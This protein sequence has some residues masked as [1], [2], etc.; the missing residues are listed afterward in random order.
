MG[1]KKLLKGIDLNCINLVN[2][3]Y[4]NVIL[5]NK[6]EVDEHIISTTDTQHRI[7]F[8]L[9]EGKSGHLFR[10][11]EI[12][13]LLSA[14]FSK[15]EDNGIPVY[16]HR[17]QI[18]VSGATENVKTLLKQL[19]GSDYFAAIQLKNGIVEIYG[20][21]NLLKTSNYDYESQSPL[22]GAVIQMVSKIE[23]YEPPYV[24]YAAGFEDA[25]FNDLFGGI[26]GVLSGDFNDDFNDDFYIGN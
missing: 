16:E 7:S 6:S 4:Q 23:E 10:A 20:F 25:H 9:L 13:S 24:Y 3:Y 22:G 11:S 12:T 21:D 17:V 5:I 1:C 18:P 14:S 26:E 2:K 19:D 8:N 15:S